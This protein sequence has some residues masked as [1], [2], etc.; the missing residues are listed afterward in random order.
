MAKT[1]GSHSRPL[2]TA[3]QT[4]AYRELLED[5]GASSAEVAEKIGEAIFYAIWEG[6]NSPNGT[7]RAKTIDIAL[8]HN[9]KFK[10][11]GGSSPQA[12]K[13]LF[14]KA[15]PSAAAGGD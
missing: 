1:K 3:E 11:I 12:A 10:F 2:F 8:K 15:P 13:N 14:G 4:K 7:I 5:K 6:L 9:G